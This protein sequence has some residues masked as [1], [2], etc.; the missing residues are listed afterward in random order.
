MARSIPILSQ[1]LDSASS[2]GKSSMKGCLAS[3]GHDCLGS[4]LVPLI[5]LV[6]PSL[7]VEGIILSSLLLFSTTSLLL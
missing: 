4:L 6:L 1:P 3:S 2:N 7:L 5:T